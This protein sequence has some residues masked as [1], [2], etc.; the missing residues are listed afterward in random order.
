MPLM[1]APEQWDTWMAGSEEEAANLLKPSKEL[2]E[3]RARSLV[4]V[5]VS[6]WVNDPKHDDPKCLD[7]ADE[8]SV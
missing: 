8:S 7:P 6:K 1:L 4:L 2:L 3:E 5:P